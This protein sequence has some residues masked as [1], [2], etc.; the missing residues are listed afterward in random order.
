MTQAEKKA[1]YIGLA[2]KHSPATVI[3]LLV[4]MVADAEKEIAKLKRT[5][6]KNGRGER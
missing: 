3:E 5:T 2:K 4:E 6:R 1:Y